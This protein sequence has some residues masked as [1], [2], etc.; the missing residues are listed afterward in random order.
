MSRE[1]IFIYD[2]LFCIEFTHNT[3]Y[4]CW[5]EKTNSYTFP[6]HAA[7]PYFI[8]PTPT[9]E[10]SNRFSTRGYIITWTRQVCRLL[11]PRVFD[12]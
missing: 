12:I 7:M 4:F 6:T 8:S 9:L 5:S 3:G 1:I 2:W 11:V 10:T